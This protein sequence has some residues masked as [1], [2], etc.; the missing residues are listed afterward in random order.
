MVYITRITVQ[1][2]KSF[3]SRKTV[4]RLGPGLTVITGPNGGG[5]SSVIDAIKFALGELS[6]HNLR[7]GRFSELLHDSPAEG[8]LQSARVTLTLDNRDRVLPVDADEVTLTRRLVA[9][10]ESEY[11]LNGRQVSRSEI[12]AIL[13][14]ANIRPDGL[15]IVTQGSVVGLAEM[16]SNELRQV[17]EDV[18]GIAEYKRKREDAN[19]QLEIAE[20]NLAIAKASTGEVRNRVKQLERE[21]NQLLRRLLCEREAN[22]LRSAE[23]RREHH[24]LAESLKNVD[25]EVSK[26][27]EELDSVRSLRESLF[28]RRSEIESAIAA[29]EEELRRRKGEMSDV[30]ERIQELRNI[31][32][33]LGAQLSSLEGALTQLNA[34][35]GS[36]H[37]RDE[38]LKQAIHEQEAEKA[39]LEE[40][41]PAIREELTEHNIRIEA[42]A[43]TLTEKRKEL[44]EKEKHLAELMQELRRFNVREDG[45]LLL[46]EDLER[47]LSEVGEE[48]K[49]VEQA[50]EEAERK[51]KEFE[52]KVN[53]LKEQEKTLSLS[54]E[55]REK[56]H[57]QILSRLA[58][59]AE[60]YETLNQL[61]AELNALISA[62]NS[63]YESSKHENGSSRL[64]TLRQILDIPEED[65][66]LVSAILDGWMYSVVCRTVEEAVSLAKL[67]AK[68]GL[69]LKAIP[70]NDK[71]DA[72]EVAK[73]VFGDFEVV[74]TV[75]EL[76]RRRGSRVVSRDGVV[77]FEDGRVS[78]AGLEDVAE[79][80]RRE[81]GRLKQ[82]LDE[83]EKALSRIAEKRGTLQQAAADNEQLIE[84]YRRKLNEVRATIPAL[85]ERISTTK[86]R[87]NEYGER[88]KTLN[89]MEQDIRGRIAEINES[90]PVI[91][92][93]LAEFNTLNSE[94]RELRSLVERMEREVEAARN[95][96]DKAQNKLRELE[97]RID[98]LETGIAAKR[99]QLESISLELER[100]E[101]QRSE[102]RSKIEELRRQIT[103]NEEELSRVLEELKEKRNAVVELEERIAEH[104][105][106]L[107]NVNGELERVASE[108]EALDKRL[109]M[110]QMERV[111]LETQLN[112]VREKL[113]SMGVS[114]DE[115]LEYPLQQVAG[116][117]LPALEREL[118]ELSAIN[119]LA[120]TQYEAIIP[121]YK[122]RSARINELELE[123]QQIIEFIRSID[124]E[125]TA[126][127]MRTFDKV[128]EAFGFFFHQ[129]TGGEAWLRLEDPENPLKSGVEMVVKFVGKQARSSAAVSGGEKSVAATS[130]ILALQGMTPA[131]FYIF[132]EIDAH[133]DINYTT[134]LAALL[135]EMS[136]NKQ[137][138][139]VTLKDAIAEKADTLYGVYMR[140]GVSSIVKTTL[141][142]VVAVG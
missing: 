59:L 13:S 8:K 44:T 107:K 56:N 60:R 48:K 28:S 29:L 2:F 14:A 111:R 103:D 65:T 108:A 38:Q 117:I 75:D 126:A 81:T 101:S 7:V 47:R 86:A 79:A 118:E 93:R 43:S 26:I 110:L 62:I 130:L 119:Q 35:E 52:V 82:L 78:V 17:V 69:P 40:L 20:K 70:L 68:E 64:K 91:D 16:N 9:S 12:L 53:E 100:I 136:N 1:G 74:D 23:L 141:E 27:V 88:L 10:G 142:E 90:R 18:A 115:P 51:L 120:A 116:D 49:R 58:K 113:D 22:K 39:R 77:M 127:F 124:A 104:R 32:T 36:I 98:R 97:R 76:L 87:I 46:L 25:E 71:Q 66:A 57:E 24:R 31:S 45:R 125:E 123:R 34:M 37:G 96:A 133:L 121:N 33:R 11:L 21:R 85:E 50:L 137:I 61:R 80:Y 19:E 94:V 122:V 84:E 102:I 72:H 67:A 63:F 92:E 89:G 128:S 15:N 95:E 6:A 54:L 138:I 112:V 114:P 83:V 99:E 3:G 134:R 55:G 30:E 41:I 129:I 106:Q 131:E 5:K 105:E 73:R 139:I 135:K 42:L 132:D 140:N 4:I 109:N